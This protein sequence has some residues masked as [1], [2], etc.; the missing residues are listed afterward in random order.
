MSG[1]H[2]WVGSALPYL[3]VATELTQD[4]YREIVACARTAHRALCQS[5]ALANGVNLP[6]LAHVR[7]GKSLGEFLLRQGTVADFRLEEKALRPK[8]LFR[9]LAQLVRQLGEMR[10]RVR[11]V[12]FKSLGGI[13]ALQES[14]WKTAREANKPAPPPA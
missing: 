7:A 1:H 5:L 8:H 10:E 6:E 12:H 14:I 4:E 3:S 9:S 13:L 2:D 11:R